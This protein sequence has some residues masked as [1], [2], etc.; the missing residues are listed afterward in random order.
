MADSYDVVVVGAGTGGYSTALRAA[1]LGKRVAI[2][3]RDDRLGGTCLLR[4]CIPTK[5][6]LQS[7]AVMDTVN[8][9]GGM[10]HQG[11]RRP[12]LVGRAG[13]RGQDRR[14][15][16]QGR[17]RSHQDARHRRAEGNRKLLAG[18]AVEVDGTQDRR[19][20]RRDRERIASAL[21]PGIES[22]RADHHERRGPPVRQD[23][24]LRGRDRGRRRRPRVRVALPVPRRRGHRPWRRFPALAPLEDEDISK[25]IAQGVPPARDQDRG[26]RIGEDVSDTGE[27]VDV[28]FEA[29]GQGRTRSPP[30]SASSRSAAGR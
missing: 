18:P 23:P 14:Q 4:G 2:V 22:D 27:A 26:R 8:R 5:A 25:E 21:L 28:T 16:R 12:R 17:H 7:A 20:R 9:A 1:Q 6:L 10:G 19:G 30:T 11:L 3:E 13:V 24:Q 15:A 29:D